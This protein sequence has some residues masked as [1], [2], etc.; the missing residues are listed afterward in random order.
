MGVE[1]DNG[2]DHRLTSVGEFLRELYI[3]GGIPLVLIG[4]GTVN[5]FLPYKDPGRLLVTSLLI[6][7]G[8]L[9]WGASL[10]VSVLR[11]RVRAR[12]LAEQDSV[13]LR[14]ICD[15]A[16][17]EKSDVVPGK[18][19][20]LGDALGKVGVRTIEVTSTQGGHP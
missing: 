11:W 17:S 16:R 13:I 20:A 14:A 2:L 18:I 15:I 8:A 19:A 3:T 7:V 10:Y 5:L 6:A 1:L 9:S 12:I 4:V